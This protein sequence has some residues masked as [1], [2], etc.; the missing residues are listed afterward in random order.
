MQVDSRVASEIV[1]QW[2]KWNLT[3]RERLHCMEDS[4]VDI[5]YEEYDNCV[6]DRELETGVNKE[7]SK[8]RRL[9]SSL[10]LL[11]VDSMDSSDYFCGIMLPDNGSNNANTQVILNYSLILQSSDVS[12][13]NHTQNT[14]QEGITFGKEE[15][16]EA[17]QT[18]QTELIL[19]IVMIAFIMIT[20][21]IMFA[22]RLNQK[23]QYT[24]TNTN[25]RNDDYRSVSE[26]S[27]DGY[28][29]NSSYVGPYRGR[30][31]SI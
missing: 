27:V 4:L 5:E 15:N 14:R 28:H 18:S 2:Y 3:G 17:Y 12:I 19:I 25:E 22:I 11:K 1:I 20:I 26:P 10:T 24:V 23:A 29:D 7:N 30:E 31:S 16:K 6:I 21:L 13:H 8:L 9:K